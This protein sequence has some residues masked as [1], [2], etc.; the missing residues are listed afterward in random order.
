MFGLVWGNKRISNQLQISINSLYMLK[1]FHMGASYKDFIATKGKS[2]SKAFHMRSFRWRQ[3]ELC[4]IYATQAVLPQ[5]TDLRFTRTNLQFFTHW[6][7]NFGTGNLTLSCLS[8]HAPKI[9]II[10]SALFGYSF[11]CSDYN[12]NR[13]QSSWN[14]VPLG[15]MDWVHN[16]LP[17]SGTMII[18]GQDKQDPG[19]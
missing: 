2:F 16:F 18:L 5:E 3:C 17:G 6:L 19:P 13:S 1:Y 9:L 14:P 11:V 12:G 15:K 8:L 7:F 4:H 10:L